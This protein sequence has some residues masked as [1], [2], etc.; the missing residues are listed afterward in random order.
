[1][2][3]RAQTDDRQRCIGPDGREYVAVT[4]SKNRAFAAACLAE[5][6]ARDGK[7]R[8]WMMQH[9]AVNVPADLL[10]SVRA[11]LDKEA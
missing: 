11:R 6:A 5:M 1:M 9:K 7:D 4:V 2:T 8:R 3:N 10:P